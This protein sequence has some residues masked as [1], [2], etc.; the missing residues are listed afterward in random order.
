MRGHRNE[1]DV[2]QDNSEKEEEQKQHDTTID[3]FKFICKQSNQFKCI[4]TK[5][6]KLLDVASFLAPVRYDSCTRGCC[7]ESNHK[8]HI[9]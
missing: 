4:V 6:F 7:P 2:E 9:I 3:R 1:R 5:K 8:D